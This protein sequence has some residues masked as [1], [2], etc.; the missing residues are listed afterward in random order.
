MRRKKNPNLELFSKR[1]KLR[2]LPKLKKLAEKYFHKYICLRDKNVCFTC[3]KHGNQAGHFRHNRLDFDEINLN[4]QCT[5]CNMYLSGNLGIYAVRLIKKYGQDTIDDLIARSYKPHKYTREE[6]E[7]Y[8]RIYKL[9]V[10][11]LT[12]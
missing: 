6:L 2:P 10:K 7:E 3:D 9:K 1:K 8:L 5:Y 11:N 4:C 12:P